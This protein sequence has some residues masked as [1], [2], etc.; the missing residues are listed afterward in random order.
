MAD[1]ATVAR[2]G[3]PLTDRER[4]VLEVMRTADSEAAAASELGISPHTVDTHLRN[5]RSKLAV[6]TTRQA[7]AVTF[8]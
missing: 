7:I 2:P 5:I 8:G 4:R 1:V 3:S 6:R